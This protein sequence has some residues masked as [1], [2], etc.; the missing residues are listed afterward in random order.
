MTG[1]KRFSFVFHFFCGAAAAARQHES[2]SASV[3]NFFTTVLPAHLN[4][5]TPPARLLWQKTQ[6]LAAGE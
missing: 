5:Q 3:S 6:T 2:V 4:L 1:S